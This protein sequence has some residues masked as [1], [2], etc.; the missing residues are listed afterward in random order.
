MRQAALTREPSLL[1]AT[2]YL[3]PAQ[4]SGS[5]DFSDSHELHTL[6][7]HGGEIV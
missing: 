5:D 2:V 4:T 1:N 7:P 6:V 3:G